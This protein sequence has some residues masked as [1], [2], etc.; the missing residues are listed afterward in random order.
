MTNQI[1]STLFEMLIFGV[2]GLGIEVCFT[3]L[4]TL[5]DPRRH[6]MGF[7]S[8]WY[9]PLYALAPL[10]LNIASTSLFALP[11][12]VRGLIYVAVFYALEYAGMLALRL[13]VGASPSEESYYKSRWNI[14]GLIRLDFAP[15]IFLLGAFLEMVY[16]FLH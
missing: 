6:L 8:I 15:A 7:S 3:A 1:L 14:H 11:F 13:L 16:R 2:L 12:V 4:W 10:I 5:K 9:I